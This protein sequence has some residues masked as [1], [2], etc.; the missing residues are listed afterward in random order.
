MPATSWTLVARSDIDLTKYV[1]KKVELKGTPDS[2]G[3]M[4]GYNSESSTRSAKATDGPRFHVKSVRVLAE[5][6]S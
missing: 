2:K 6:C 1:G 4:S 3:G 5:T